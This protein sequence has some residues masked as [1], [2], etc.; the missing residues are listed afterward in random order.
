MNLPHRCQLGRGYHISLRARCTQTVTLF[1]EV[2]ESDAAVELDVVALK[3][4]VEAERVL[5]SALV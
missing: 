5:G 3:R 2:A 4:E 1:N